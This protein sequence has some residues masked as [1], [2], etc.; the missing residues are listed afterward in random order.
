M[1]IIVVDDEPAVSDIVKGVCLAA[2]YTC[3]T[4]DSYPDDP[5][6]ASLIITDL[7]GPGPR[8]RDI[9]DRLEAEG[10]MTPIIVLTAATGDRLEQLIGSD[11]KPI[12]VVTK[13]FSIAPL[14][15]IIKGILG[16]PK[17]TLL[18]AVRAL[19]FAGY[20]TCAGSTRE[21]QAAL[22]ERLRDAAGIPEGAATEAGVG[23]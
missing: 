18:E 14:T 7:V 9:C 22:W 5:G 20:W 15:Q 1:R 17:E 16:E 21:K 11:W 23:D 8:G 13:P 19:Y 12:A 6:P 4:F 2:G 3:D 10:N